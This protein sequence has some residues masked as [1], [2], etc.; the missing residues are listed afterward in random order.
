LFVDYIVKECNGSSHT[1]G[2][3]GQLWLPEVLKHCTY[4]GLTYSK[5]EKK[6]LENLRLTQ[7]VLES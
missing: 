3:T 1:I 6:K 7:E 5:Y 4:W 2:W